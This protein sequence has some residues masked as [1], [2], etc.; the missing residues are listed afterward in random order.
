MVPS[1]RSA[2]ENLRLMAVVAHPDDE[3]LGMGGTMARCAS[4]GIETALITATRGERGRHG[5]SQSNS[6]AHLG[7]LREAVEGRRY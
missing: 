1:S 6:P 2:A 3:S 5:A 7:A 4:D